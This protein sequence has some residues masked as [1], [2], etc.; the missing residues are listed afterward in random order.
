M[1]WSAGTYTRTNTTYNGATVWAQDEANSIDILSTRHDLHDQDLAA[2]INACLHKGGQNSMTAN[3]PMGGFKITGAADGTAD[4]DLATKGQMDTAI[5]AG[6]GGITEVSDD[7]SP[8]LG[9]NLQMDGNSI[10]A[11]VFTGVITLGGNWTAVV[12]GTELIFKYNGS[13]MMR[14]TETGEIVVLEDLT[15]GTP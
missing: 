2:G 3:L 7:T 4:S 5:G 15:V 8:V 9:G 6:G 14:F 1:A 10:T 12:T 11:P 13:N